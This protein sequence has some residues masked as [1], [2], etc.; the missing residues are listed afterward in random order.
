MT[1]SDST[2]DSMGGFSGSSY[3]IKTA[4]IECLTGVAMVINFGTRLAVNGLR[5]KITTLGISYK[6]WFVFSQPLP[7]L[8]ADSGLV[9]AAVETAPGWRLSGW[10]LTR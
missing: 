2:F 4:E 5:R 9:V 10:E 8:V 1:A 3:S 7:V 6:G